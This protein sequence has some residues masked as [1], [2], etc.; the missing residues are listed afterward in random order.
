MDERSVVQQTPRHPRHARR[1]IR[2]QRLCVDNRQRRELRPQRGLQL[3][4]RAAPDLKG[5]ADRLVGGRG[6]YDVTSITPC[7][8]TRQSRPTLLVATSRPN[9]VGPPT[10]MAILDGIDT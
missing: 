4:H 3:W 8:M 6:A 1:M 5:R 9:P 7:S 10:V 2:R